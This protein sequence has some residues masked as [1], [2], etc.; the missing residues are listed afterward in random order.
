M[1]QNLR[2]IFT[3]LIA[4][5]QEQELR[6]GSKRD[7]ELTALA[8]KVAPPRPPKHPVCT[9]FILCKSGIGFLFC[10]DSYQKQAV[11]YAIQES[12]SCFA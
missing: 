11:F 10:I 4:S 8:D 2:E 1:R 6:G 9:S 3:E 5:S 12:N 7:L